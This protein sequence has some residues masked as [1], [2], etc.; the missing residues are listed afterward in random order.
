MNHSSR[1]LTVSNLLSISRAV[2]IIPFVAV[3]LSAI[4][5]S[6]LWA[7]L[8]MVVA[9]LTDK[10]DGVLARRLHEVTD[11]GKILQPFASS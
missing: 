2:L 6:R 8:I 10:F 11:W 3:I 9:A 7:C 5:G 4:P 1:F